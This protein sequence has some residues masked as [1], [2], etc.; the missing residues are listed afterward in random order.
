MNRN[1]LISIF[2]KHNPNTEMSEDETTAMFKVMLSNDPNLSCDL[3]DIDTE[4]NIYKHMKPL[5]ETF[6]A[7]VFL[8]K[9][10]HLTTLKMSLGA[11]VILMYHIESPG[12]AVMY[13]FYLSTKLPKNTVITVDKFA[14]IFPWGFFSEKQLNEIWSAQKVKSENCKGYTCIGAQDNMI[15]YLEIWK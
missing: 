6:Q 1:K 7:R 8:S 10:K 9:L 15:D 12:K 13:T 11:L 4:S 3:D 2:E 14:E 5:L